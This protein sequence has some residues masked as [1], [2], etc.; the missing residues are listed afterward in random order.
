MKSITSNGIYVKKKDLDLIL[1]STYKIDPIYA[2]TETNSKFYK[3][4]L[5]NLLPFFIVTVITIALLGYAKVSNAL[6]ESN[7]YYYKLYFNTI[8]TNKTSLSQ[9]INDLTSIPLK[10]NEDYFFIL[11]DNI[12]ICSS[13]N[14]KVLHTINL[15]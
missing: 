14:G 13:K 6:G 15:C 9:L 4:L 7:Y 11:T 10:S 5:Y 3:N 2:D 1:H 8:N 12:D